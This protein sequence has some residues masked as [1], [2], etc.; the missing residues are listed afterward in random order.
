MDDGKLVRIESMPREGDLIT[1]EALDRLRWLACKPGAIEA[2]LQCAERY[3][4]LAQRCSDLDDRCRQLQQQCDALEMFNERYI[5]PAHV[6]YSQ[7]T[8]AEYS[9]NSQVNVEEPVTGLGPPYVNG[10]PVPPGAVI[11]LTHKARPGYTP[12][13]IAIDLNIAGGASNYLDFIITMYLVPGGVSSA[14][15]LEI[16]NQ[17]RG[18][19]FLNKDGSQ[20]HLKFPEWQNQPLDI[21]SAETLAIEIR[22]AGAVNNLDSAFVTIYYDNRR[23]YEL[24]KKRCGCPTP[25]R[26]TCP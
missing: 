12:T 11:R 5:C 9:D 20:V 24:C 23:F 7:R 6:L 25:A 22:N 2:V 26:A 19:Q 15:G 3:P 18:N 13:K 4:M 8:I 21:G 17:M 10:F 16:G 14:K 1:Q